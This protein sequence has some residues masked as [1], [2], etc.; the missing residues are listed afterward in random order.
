[1]SGKSNAVA[2][3]TTAVIDGRLIP[4]VRTRLQ[5]DGHPVTAV[6][7]GH[8]NRSDTSTLLKYWLKLGSQAFNRMIFK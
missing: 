3:A 4:I 1:M 6:T 7:G 8:G 5:F 2:N